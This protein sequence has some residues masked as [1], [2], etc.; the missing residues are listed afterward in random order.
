MGDNVR[1]VSA[2]KQ[3]M[4]NKA[5]ASKKRVNEVLG[6]QYSTIFL[7]AN[8]VDPVQAGATAGQAYAVFQKGDEHIFFGYGYGDSSIDDGFGNKFR[9]TR[10]E[11]S[12]EYAYRLNP[13]TMMCI[14]RIFVKAG[15]P[16]VKY[17]NPVSEDITD[18]VVTAVYT[19]A[20]DSSSKV[21]ADL[22][23]PFGIVLPKELTLGPQTLHQAALEA[24]RDVASLEFTLGSGGRSSRRLGTLRLFDSGGEESYLK[25]FGGNDSGFGMQLPEGILWDTENQ[26]E[27]RVG[28][29]FR[30]ERP[31]VLP[32]TLTTGVLDDDEVTNTLQPT[33]I[34]LPITLVVEGTELNY[35]EEHNR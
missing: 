3:V 17:A 32:L 2:I 31:A 13:M 23:D 7:T 5:L 28:F 4:Y 9:A 1:S 8:V 24:V 16:R 35:G 26:P 25:A 20:I 21:P 19:G 27:G 15:K 33:Q 18:P 22:H 30:M 6:R 12:I 10:A 11:T 14:E 34:V 29:L